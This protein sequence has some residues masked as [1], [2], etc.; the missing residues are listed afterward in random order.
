MANR[1]RFHSLTLA[2]FGRY[3][4][5]TRFRLDGRSCTFTSRNELGKSTFQAGLLATLFGPPGVRAKAAVFQ[6]RYRSWHGPIAFCGELEFTVNGEP[7]RIRQDFDALETKVWRLSKDG[8]AELRV[9]FKSKGGR[10]QADSEQYSSLLRDWLGIS[11]VLFYEAMFTISQESSLSA[12]WQVDPRIA[13]LLYGPAVERLGNSLHELFDRFRDISRNTR[14]FQIS[15]GSQGERNGRSDG[16]LDQVLTRIDE[17]GS[18]LQAA[19]ERVKSLSDHRHRLG[20]LTA[21]SD[22]LREQLAQTADSLEN[23]RRWMDLESRLQP[24]VESYERLHELNEQ[25]QQLTRPLAEI[26]TRLT[27][28]DLS[29]FET[30]HADTH[31]RLEYYPLLQQAA[32]D[33]KERLTSTVDRA[34]QARS[35]LAQLEA[36]LTSE[37]AHISG[38]AELA[39]QVE[40][41]RL[42][43]EEITRVQT[44]LQQLTRSDDPGDEHRMALHRQRAELEPWRELSDKGDHHLTD[45]RTWVDTFCRRHAEFEAT[46]AAAAST[47]AW[48]SEQDSAITNRNDQRDELARSR[49]VQ[50]ESLAAAATDARAAAERAH[51]AADQIAAARAELNRRYVDFAQAPANLIESWDRL[52][53]C[54]EQQ[55]TARQNIEQVAAECCSLDRRV[56]WR[57]VLTACG[58]SIAILCPILDYGW[59]GWVCATLAT[60]LIVS[61]RWLFRVNRAETAERRRVAQRSQADL[62][63]LGPQRE[64]LI[65]QLGSQFV[66]PPEREAEWRRL[67]PTYCRELQL[68]DANQRSLP[69]AQQIADWNRQA[70]QLDSQLEQHKSETLELL[71]EIDQ[72][73]SRTRA[74]RVRRQCELDRLEEQMQIHFGE[75]FAAADPYDAIAWDALPAVWMPVLQLVRA[76]APHVLTVSDLIAWCRSLDDTAWWRFYESCRELRH[77][78]AQLAPD[79]VELAAL[80]SAIH[81]AREEFAALEEHD[82]RLTVAILPFTAET[83]VK[84]LRDCWNAYLTRHTELEAMQREQAALPDLD[85]LAAQLQEAEHE[86][87]EAARVLAPLLDRFDHDPGR[88]TAA[89]AERQRLTEQARELDVRAATLL[90]N[91]GFVSLEQLAHEAGKAEGLVGTIRA[92][93]QELLAKASE[94]WQAVDAPAELARQRATQLDTSRTELQ[95]ELDVVE[96]ERAELVATVRHIET[97]PI[98]DIAS[99]ETELASLTQERNDL[100]RRRNQVAAEFQEANRL[101]QEL[102][103]V[104]RIALEGRITAYFADFSR[105]ANRRIE[106]DEELR[107]TVRNDDGTRYSPDQLSHG[108]RDQLYLAVYLATTAG[109]DLPFILDD[110]FVNCDVERLA[111]IRAC[112][113]RLIPSHQLILLSHDPQLAAWAP[114]IEMAEAA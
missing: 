85:P 10:N 101:M 47:V 104:E 83:D 7:W 78:D 5:P 57:R 50:E 40:E 29:V 1:V 75:Y 37:F 84:W 44:R 91:C 93:S 51:A 73:L 108:A 111:A 42:V 38:R 49:R 39:D 9:H 77:L 56:L 88:V 70:A 113:D 63:R 30:I 82:Q 99:L 53:E 107:I 28:S 59:F 67:W 102:K 69:T 105:T 109:L 31:E 60:A 45:L 87:A 48:L 81:Q 66:V 8:A 20:E 100:E 23:W 89:L 92:E 11:D 94:L 80:Q 18:S 76:D 27:G 79:P 61:L 55:A 21:R 86:L 3:D 43:R 19:R 71:D 36:S 2:G 16:R 72:A 98:N 110:P 62:L 35:R 12:S 95:R 74:E 64:Q 6:S 41:L 32:R 15:V 46:R 68:L 4:R 22:Q 114:S 96:R 26:R 103:R 34:E 17:V 58:T 33:A 25:C 65:A 97:D 14:E 112:W 54:E 90:A 52:H 24:A 13:S 106:L